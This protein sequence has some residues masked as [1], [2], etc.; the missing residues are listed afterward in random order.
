MQYN[1]NGVTI[2]N[3]AGHFKYRRFF[4]HIQNPN[5]QGRVV[6]L[7][8]GH[9]NVKTVRR[10]NCTQQVLQED[11]N[12]KKDNIVDYCRCIFKDNNFH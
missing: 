5:I 9:V 6:A 8:V 4:L 10:Y 7:F 1:N 12:D 2:G 3:E 11:H